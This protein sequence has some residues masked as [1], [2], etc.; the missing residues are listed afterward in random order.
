MDLIGGRSPEGLL[1]E[2]RQEEMVWA[3]S[4]VGAAEVESAGRI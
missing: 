2:G 1:Q 4:R 3:W